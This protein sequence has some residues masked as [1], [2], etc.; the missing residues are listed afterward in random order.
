[1]LILE[2]KCFGC[3]YG[4][5]IGDALGTRYEFLS[6]NKTKLK[7]KEDM[8]NKFLPI[9]GEGPFYK[10]EGE[11]TDDGELALCLIYSLLNKKYENNRVAKNYIKWYN[12]NPIDIGIST[13]KAL[14]GAKNY[15]DIL[16][17]SKKYNMNSLS[18]GCLMRIS[19]LAIYGINITN[20]KLKKLVK[21]NCI[22][23]N[24]NQITID[25]TIVY[26]LAIKDCLKNKKKE[27]ILSNA[28]KNAK[29]QQVKELLIEALNKKKY[30]IKIKINNK[31]VNPDSQ[32]YMGYFGFAFKNAFFQLNNGN[33][34]YNS[35]IQT[36]KL[37]GDTDTNGCIA[38][39]LL[40]AFYGINEIPEE[41]I[42]TVNNPIYTQNRLVD[43]PYINAKM[44]T[45]I[46]KKLLKN[47]KIYN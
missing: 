30:S 11:V 39:A 32:Q 25:A 4:Q 6:S 10:G 34:F 23:T 29:T 38:G 18:N 3:F 7:I 19:P 28:L 31:F 9:L 14:N 17:R 24:P 20:T 8:V 35:L 16:I 2:N 46:I 21:D 5:I 15:N 43:F 13:R 44:Y 45:K 42:N 26:V 12:S 33:D 41:W 36:I 37:G 27:E 1:M 47:N 22:M 40:G